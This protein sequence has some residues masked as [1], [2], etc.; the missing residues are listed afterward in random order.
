MA[1][2]FRDG[3]NPYARRPVP[4]WSLVLNALPF[5]RAPESRPGPTRLRYKPPRIRTVPPILDERPLDITRS[6]T[7]IYSAGYR[8]PR[9][10]V[11]Q[12]EQ[13]GTS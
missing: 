13:L 2:P 1:L 7:M 4:L 8:I 12:P 10:Y 5:M 3:N 11:S 6:T 9:I